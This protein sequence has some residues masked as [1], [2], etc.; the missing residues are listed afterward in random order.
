MRL[1]GYNR[2]STD[3]QANTGRSLEL[4]P[5]AAR[6]WCEAMGHELVAVVDDPGVSAGKVAF[7][8]RPGGAEVVR[9]LEAGEADGVLVLSFD[10]AF[11]IAVDGLLS[12]EWFMSRGYSFTSIREPIDITSDH[13]WLTFGTMCLIKEF[14]RRVIVQRAK[15]TTEGLRQAG[16]VYGP[17]PYGFVDHEGR[18]FRDPRTWP[19]R[20]EIVDLARV[21]ELSS[22]DIAKHLNA[23]MVQAPGGKGRGGKETG[24]RRWHHTTV[25]NILNN[26]DE[27]KHIPALPD[28]LESEFSG[29]EA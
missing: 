4:Q 2:V 14:E 28:A 12:A 22:R 23:C 16:R 9:L 17:V 27:L 24:G 21:D 25:L 18:L 26:H 5:E 3:E 6:R 13:G 10:R 19:V 7:A 15:E 11:R 1:I 8:D 29:K 20:Q